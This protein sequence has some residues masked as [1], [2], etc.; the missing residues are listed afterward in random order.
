MG[1]DLR[2]TVCRKGK[3]SSDG[4]FTGGVELMDF[5]T[6]IEASIQSS[7]SNQLD[8]IREEILATATEEFRMKLREAMGKVAIRMSDFYSIERFAQDIVIH[9]KIEGERNGNR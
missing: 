3:K 2:F 7:I 5:V 1:T 6:G 4:V 9:V 8:A